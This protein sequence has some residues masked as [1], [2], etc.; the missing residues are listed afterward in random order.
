ML[1]EMGKPIVRE[2]IYKQFKDVIKDLIQNK[3]RWSPGERIPTERILAEEFRISRVTIAKALSEL[4]AEGLIEKRPPVGTF[5]TNRARSKGIVLFLFCLEVEQE[6]L[7]P[8]YG[9]VLSTVEAEVGAHGYGVLFSSRDRDDAIPVTGALVVGPFLDGELDRIR[10]TRA[11]PTVLVDYGREVDGLDGVEIDNAGGARLATE[12]LLRR[13]HKR[14]AYL[15]CKRNRAG[16]EWPN[17]IS[18]RE[19]CHS[20]LRDA[21]VEVSEALDRV[22]WA[23]AGYGRRVT[24]EMLAGPNPPTA[25]L[26]FSKAQGDGAIAGARA[27]GLAAPGEFDVVSFAG[28]GATLP[29]PAG[30][31]GLLLFPSGAIGAAAARLMCARLSGAAGPAEHVVLQP[32]LATVSERVPDGSGPGTGFG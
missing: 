16:D 6:N 28:E 15:G 19:G 26:A 12:W 3:G 21:G 4:E 5:V 25:V 17:S 30:H 32:R 18:R 22:I 7:T 20:A 10:R 1:S 27:R 8:E 14:I 31:A 11:K 9:R 2:P 24:E 23:D 29:D 13:G